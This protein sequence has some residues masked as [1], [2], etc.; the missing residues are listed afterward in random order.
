MRN[1]IDIL[2]E[3]LIAGV[4]YTFN[5]IGVDAAGNVSPPQNFTL[6]YRGAGL[7]G[8]DQESGNSAAD[9][10]FILVGTWSIYRDMPFL[11]QGVIIFCEPTPFY[12]VK[13]ENLN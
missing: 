5:I 10:S 2:N 9:I 11:L 6:T 1:Q 4:E 8:F 3:E 12:Q 13:G 7:I